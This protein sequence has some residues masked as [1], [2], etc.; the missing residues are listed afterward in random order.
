MSRG[1]ATQA[2]QNAIASQ[3]GGSGGAGGNNE[4]AFGWAAKIA[5]VAI[6][7]TAMTSGVALC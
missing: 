3:E 5:G 4:G 2:S 7:M 1:F 6:A